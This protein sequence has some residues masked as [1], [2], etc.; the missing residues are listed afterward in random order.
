MNEEK[1]QEIAASFANGI[2]DPAALAEVHG[3]ARS[4]I[5]G[6]PSRHRE[7]WNTI[8][9]E[10]GVKNRTFRQRPTRKMDP[11][12]LRKI[13]GMWDSLAP[14]PPKKRKATISRE[15]RMPISTL[16]RYLKQIGV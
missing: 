15:L 2:T 4:T 6:I 5:E 8:L 1:I 16:H 10:F 11:E 9:D 14:L 7:I 3:F 12:K 13:K